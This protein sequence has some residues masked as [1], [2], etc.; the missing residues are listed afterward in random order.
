MPTLVQFVTIV[1]MNKARLK[2]MKSF[3]KELERRCDVIP[4]P[5]I[6]DEPRGTSGGNPMVTAINRKL[7]YETKIK[8]YESMDVLYEKWI[9]S[10]TPRELTIFDSIYMKD[11]SI[12]AV[13]EQLKV[14]YQLVYQY[15]QKLEKKWGDFAQ[16]EGLK[17]E[18]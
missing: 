14:T 4:G 10:L 1:K 7:D 2:R 5:R 3:L 16:K 15:K 11:M 18:Q 9:K 13:S 8:W 17:N 6:S 12:E